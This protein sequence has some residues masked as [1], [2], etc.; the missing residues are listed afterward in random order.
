[1]QPLGRLFAA[2]GHPATRV[3]T[4]PRLQAPSGSACQPNGSL[5]SSSV[6]QAPARA[7]QGFSPARRRRRPA[8]CCRSR[9]AQ[10]A[11]HARQQRHGK[12]VKKKS[13]REINPADAHRCA[14]LDTRA[15]FRACLH[16]PPAA[17]PTEPLPPA[18]P[19]S[20]RCVRC[21]KAERLKEIKRNKQERSLQRAAL[22]Q[23][24]AEFRRA[25]QAWLRRCSL[26]LFAGLGLTPSHLLPRMRGPAGMTPRRCASSSRRSWSWSSRG[27]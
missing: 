7:Y 25:G 4:S 2:G 10:A 15:P 27:R 18:C 21:R 16:L 26:P 14:R 9:R 17:K 24:C 11:G 1:M 20:R 6:Q 19:T 22:K 3:V 12:M 13:G 8:A 23:R 5:N